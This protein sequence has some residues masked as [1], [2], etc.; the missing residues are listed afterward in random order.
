MS[1]S[2][3]QLNEETVK[4]RYVIP[5][6]ERLSFSPSELKLEGRV[7]LRI[8]RFRFK[9]GI[10][11]IL[12]KRGDENL[13]L[14]EVKAE[15]KKLTQ[16]DAGQGI[17]YASLIRPLPPFVVLTNGKDWKLYE[18]LT[19][20][21][22]TK[23][24]ISPDSDFK[25]NL[26]EGWEAEAL[27]YFLGLSVENLL[28][29]SKAQASEELTELIGSK[30]NPSPKFIPELF[31][32]REALTASFERYVSSPEPVFA[33]LADSGSGKTCCLCHLTQR[34][35]REKRPVLFYRGT[36]LKGPLLEA[37]ATD[38]KWTFSE[39]VSEVTLVRRLTRLVGDGKL[40]VVVDAI[41]EWEY[42]S[43]SQDILSVAKHF[44]G[45]GIKLVASCKLGA[46]CSF[47]A[48]RGVESGLQRYI[49]KGTGDDAGFFLGPMSEKEFHFAYENY[50]KFYG[51]GRGAEDVAYR[52]AR[53]SPF[54][55][56]VMFEVTQK[57][58]GE[59]ILLSTVEFYKEYFE[60]LIERLNHTDIG[61][62]MLLAIAR[63]MFSR[64]EERLTELDLLDVPVVANSPE[65]LDEL[66][67][68]QVL[69]RSDSGEGM[70]YSFYFSLLRDY[71]VTFCVKRWHKA[72]EEEFNEDLERL[73]D[74]AT[75]QEALAFFYRHANEEKQRMVD[76]PVRARVEKLLDLYD[77][78]ISTDLRPLRDRF[79]PHT[80]GAIGYVG[81]FNPTN[82]NLGHP[83]FRILSENQSRIRL[84]PMAGHTLRNSNMTH[85]L[86]GKGVIWT[87]E[88]NHE[89]RIRNYVLNSAIGSQLRKIIDNGFLD[90][91]QERYLAEETILTLVTGTRIHYG[92]EPH[93]TERRDRPFPLKLEDVRRWLRHRFLTEHLRSKRIDEK[94]ESGE[95]PVEWDDTGY[96]FSDD[97]TYQDWIEIDKLVE[98]NL[99]R[100]DEDVR[101]FA[102][103]VY[104]DLYNLDR[105]L[106]PALDTLEKC[107][108]TE[109]A[110]PL[111]QELTDISYRI[112]LRL[113]ASH[114]EDT[115][116]SF[117]ARALPLVFGIFTR[118]VRRNF[119]TLYSYF[120]TIE[121]RPVTIVSTVR[122]M[123]VG[124]DE[125]NNI[126]MYI[127]NGSSS[128][129]RFIVAPARAVTTSH[130]ENPWR[131][132]IAVGNEVFIPREEKNLCTERFISLSRLL[133][134]DRYLEGR[135][136]ITPVLRMMVY[137][138]IRR[139]LPIAF[140]SLCSKHGVEMDEH[141]W[142][143]FSR[144]R[145]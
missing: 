77:T 122:H 37:I 133:H 8:G 32:E 42:E 20:K 39:Q 97:L 38:F 124:R 12:I 118:I 49:N 23:R 47:T 58:G 9:T 67:E 88:V 85:L 72:T 35:L 137:D 11:D 130:T 75:H 34:L 86:G 36:L 30:D 134:S 71:L 51:V 100:S 13:F 62:R 63:E 87:G 56:R 141:D 95:I 29:F 54:F 70:Q 114:I 110:G 83:E 46:W 108:I 102:T 68:F 27:K 119:P 123:T 140:A 61:R 28:A 74:S 10:Y 21:E 91:S 131:F 5:L 6:L 76:S 107:G 2:E 125:F 104:Q 17:S 3:T 115:I 101:A 33:V 15:G 142:S 60:Q 113:R 57:T 144:S 48:S 139:E 19:K 31:V 69:E 103:G 66:L 45:T 117:F 128:E 135:G 80:S 53:R 99:E 82:G 78:V 18:T 73:D 40:V 136:G 7:S 112:R 64:G 55:M 121:C 16:E 41:D 89:D 25:V 109:I 111:F 106:A 22:V 81:T 52:E 132:K 26:P 90:E 96:S 143:S 116:C 94:V 92:G 1:D 4:I 138:L 84:V 24:K 129:D 126:T 98:A 44:K 120:P 14:V 43:R 65:T 59:F 105:R 50:K 93:P 145:L 127:C 79:V